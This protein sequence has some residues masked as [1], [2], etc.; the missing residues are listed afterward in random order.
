MDVQ[1]NEERGSTCRRCKEGKDV[2]LIQRGKGR[3]VDNGLD[4]GRDV[5]SGVDGV[6]SGVD[7]MLT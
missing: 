2:W 4:S 3:G 1:A 7:V 5:G 6:G